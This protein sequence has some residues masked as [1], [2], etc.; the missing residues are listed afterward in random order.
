MPDQAGL[1]FL[2]ESA[3]GDQQPLDPG[4]CAFLNDIVD[5]VLGHRDH[6]QVH[7]TGDLGHGPVAS[8]PAKLECLRIHPVD[9]PGVSALN[10][11]V[12][13]GVPQG[14]P[15]P[16]G[17]D[18]GDRFRGKKPGQRLGFGAVFARFHHRPGLFRP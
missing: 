1:A 12:Q 4:A 9:R 18:H 7:G 11:V 2:G 14:A 17:S 16:A 10:D 5:A 8:H 15:L 13:Q 6:R 3:G